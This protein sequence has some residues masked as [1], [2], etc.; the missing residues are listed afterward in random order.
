VRAVGPFTQTELAIVRRAFARQMLAAAGVTDDRLERAFAAVRREDFLNA[1]PWQF[2]RWPAGRSLPQSDPAAVYQDVVIALQPGRGVN[3]G[4]PSLHAA[5]LHDLMVEPGQ[6]V[7]HIGAGAGYYTAIL[8]ELV[9]PSGRVSAFEFDTEL[10]IRARTNLEAWPHVTVAAADGGQAPTELV[11]RIY[12]NFAVAA[13]A[14]SWIERLEPDG[15]LLFALG[16]PHPSAQ[17]KFPRHSARGAALLVER[18]PAGLAAKYLYP[19]YFVCAEGKLSGDHDS[20]LALFAAFEKGGIE[21]IKS[22]QLD[23][24]VDATRCW[25]STARWGLSYDALDG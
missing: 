19:A 3:N 14:M 11:D 24:G 22:L 7:V 18:R 5:M 2:V 23:D 20:E 8:A 17:K 25:Y 6:H 4:S 9:G 10:A 21:F 15:K 13:P 12:V 16:A 1:A